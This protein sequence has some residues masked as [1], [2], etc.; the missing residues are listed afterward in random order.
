MCR[1]EDRMHVAR[2]MAKDGHSQNDIAEKLYVSDRMVRKYLKPDDFGTR[3]R[4]AKKSIL[5]P[6]HGFID[7]LLEDDPFINL[8]PV[9]ERLQRRAYT[10]GGRFSVDALWCRRE[11]RETPPPEAQRPPAPSESSAG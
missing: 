8:V 7:A 11:K 5:E 6:F 3:A 10:G 9:F 2:I 1:K 4:K